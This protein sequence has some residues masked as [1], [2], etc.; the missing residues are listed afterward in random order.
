MLSHITASINGLST[1]KAYKKEEAFFDKYARSEQLRLLTYILCPFYLGLGSICWFYHQHMV[2]SNHHGSFK[3]KLIHV[4]FRF[5][6]VQ[7]RNNMALLLTQ[8][9]KGWTYASAEVISV[10]I[11]ISFFLFLTL[12]PGQSVTFALTALALMSSLTVS[13]NCIYFY[14]SLRK[15]NPENLCIKK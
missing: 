11:L 15:Y 5:S 9:A 8:G 7:D 6:S 14:I 2:S 10:W 3:S 12:I 13:G 1:I 4:Y